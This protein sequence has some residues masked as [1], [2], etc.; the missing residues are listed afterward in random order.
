[1]YYSI[2]STDNFDIIPSMRKTACTCA[3]PYTRM[4]ITSHYM[5]IGFTIGSIPQ[6]SKTAKRPG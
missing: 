5:M 4:S 1:M 6:V 2:N 3:D